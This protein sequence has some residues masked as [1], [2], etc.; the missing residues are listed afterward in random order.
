MKLIETNRFPF[1]CFA[2]NA[3]GQNRKR[4]SIFLSVTQDGASLGLG[5]YRAV[6]AGTPDGSHASSGSESAPSFDYTRPGLYGDALL[7]NGRS[8]DLFCSSVSRRKKF[9]E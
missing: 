4:E 8:F 6:P 1:S 3:S 2:P 7:D 5:Y 9:P